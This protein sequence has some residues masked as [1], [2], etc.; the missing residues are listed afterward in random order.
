METYLCPKID[1]TS[2]EYTEDQAWIIVFMAVLLV[3]GVT[4]FIGMSVWCLANGY[5]GFTGDY[6]IIEWGLKVKFECY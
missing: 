2:V 3:I 5:S 4:W 6:S 1:C